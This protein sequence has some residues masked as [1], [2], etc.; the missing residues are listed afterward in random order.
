VCAEKLEELQQGLADGNAD[1]E[2]IKA[3]IHAV[4]EATADENKVWKIF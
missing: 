3:D 4:E 2:K 1:L